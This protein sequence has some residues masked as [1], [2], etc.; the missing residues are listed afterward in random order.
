MPKA[1]W[2]DNM[3]FSAGLEQDPLAD[4][5]AAQRVSLTQWKHE[6]YE[7][8]EKHIASLPAAL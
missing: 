5:D 8:L 1:E 6:Q 7:A 3:P 2:E 4:E